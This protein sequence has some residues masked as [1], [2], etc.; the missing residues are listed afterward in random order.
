[1][2]KILILLSILISPIVVLAEKYDCDACYNEF[3]VGFATATDM[4]NTCI[5]NYAFTPLSAWAAYGSGNNWGGFSSSAAAL[6]GLQNCTNTYYSIWDSLGQRF[7]Y[8]T[9]T[10]CA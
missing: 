4:Y 6:V 5:S 10:Y 7:D 9:T 8:C 1:M 3:Q 2:K